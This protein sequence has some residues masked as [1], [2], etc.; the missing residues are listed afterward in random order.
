[1][2]RL[3]LVVAPAI[4]AAAGLV[5]SC[6]SLPDIAPT[7]CGNRVVDVDS[8]DCD[9]VT[10]AS[11]ADATTAGKR[12]CGAP[13]TPAQ[14]RILCTTS[15]D[16]AGGWGCGLDGVCREPRGTFASSAPITEEADD[17]ALADFDGDGVSDIL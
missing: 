12:R 14:C 2:K 5:F 9:E 3:K 8:E 16:C 15:A 13:G 1:M 7:V 10:T 11:A 17:L 6:T 4:V